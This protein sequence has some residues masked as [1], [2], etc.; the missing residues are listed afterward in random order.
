MPTGS[1]LMRP[2]DQPA[3]PGKLEPGNSYFKIKLTDAQAFFPASPLAQADF[4]LA[5]L[6]VESA[7]GHK[8]ESLYKFPTLKKNT[9]FSLGAHIDLT[10]WLPTRNAEKITVKLEYKVTRGSPI[11]G[12]IEEL[13][14]SGLAT[15]LSLLGPATDAG[16]KV[17]EIVGHFLSFL[18]KEG[19]T[20]TIF[21]TMPIDLDAGELQTGYYAM[22]GA[23]TDQI[24]PS[25][26]EIT[27]N[28]PLRQR[29]GHDL[30]RHSYAVFKV[31]ALPR[32]GPDTFTQTSWGELLQLCRTN[33]LSALFQQ[34]EDDERKRIL[35][36]WR[37]NLGLIQTLADRDRGVLPRESQEIINHA[38]LEVEE[39][40]KP[41]T[42]KEAFI[43]E[44]YSADWQKI[45][46]VRNRQ[47]LRWAVQDYLALLAQAKQLR[48]TYER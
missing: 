17:T 45:L 5:I 3:L 22:V 23:S 2:Q 38:H 1:R 4:L 13:D 12:F 48:E 26:L 42:A 27:E 37:A 33:A 10:D 29:G 43:G 21:T 46:G 8:R 28:G 14:N 41:G 18:A 15:V 44:D 32:L 16:T 20:E 30:D 11:K 40:A 31:M 35:R 25:H 6:S 19:K 47:E 34:P 24:L 7:A 36:M 39:A 9:R